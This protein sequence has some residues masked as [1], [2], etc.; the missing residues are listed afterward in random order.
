MEC[1]NRPKLSVDEIAEGV[2]YRGFTSDDID[3]DGR[4]KT[5]TLRF[6]DI[7]CNSG[8][9]SEPQ[10]VRLRANGR[11][12]DGCFAFSIDEV[13]FEAIANAVHDPVCNS[14]RDPDNYSHCE[15]RR[16]K[17]GETFADE[18]AKHNRLKSKEKKLAW[19]SNMGRR[20]TIVL[21][22]EG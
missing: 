14:E 8:L 11:E 12:T 19:R 6:P 17:D 3:E 22:A 2:F 10:D 13:R 9:F 4:I 16:L 5:E 21:Q 1:G 7:S 20:L 15:L 18:P